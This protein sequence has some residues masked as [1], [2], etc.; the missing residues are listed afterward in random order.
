MSWWA[1]FII[2]RFSIYSELLLGLLKSKSISEHKPKPKPKFKS[3]SKSTQDGFLPRDRSFSW[4]WRMWK[5]LHSTHTNT[6]L[7][8]IVRA[9]PKALQWSLQHCGRTRSQQNRHRRESRQRT[10]REEECL[11]HQGRLSWFLFNEG[12]KSLVSDCPATSSQMLDKR[13]TCD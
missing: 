5:T 7:E 6:N 11:N 10:A 12:K 3:N 1:A 4:H 8:I 13:L 9:S 2:I